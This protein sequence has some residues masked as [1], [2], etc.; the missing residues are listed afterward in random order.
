[1]GKKNVLLGIIL[2]MVLILSL[3]IS[4][5]RIDDVPTTMVKNKIKQASIVI[6][7]KDAITQLP[8]KDSEYV[9][10][11]E[12][13]GEVIETMKT[14]AAGKATSRL[15]DYEATSYII[16]QKQ[17]MLPYKLSDVE[18]L[19]EVNAPILEFEDTNQMLDYVKEVGRTADGQIEIKKVLMNVNTLMQKPELPNGCEIVS[20]TAV[21][22]YYGYKVTKTEMSD[23]YL[24]KESFAVNENKLY[25]PDPYKAYGGNPRNLNGAFFS[26]SPPIVEAAKLYFDAVGGR[27]SIADISGS[28]KEQIIEYLNKGIPVVVWITLDLSK[29]QI[30]AGWYLNDSGE[31]FPAPVNLHVVVL[32][33]YEENLVHVM[34]PLEGQVTYNADTFFKSYDEIGSHALIVGN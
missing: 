29:P 34:N 19:V 18:F 12:A 8:I 30:N 14:D 32:N 10:M 20:L 6:I 31:Y 27:N 33:G 3:L 9:I 21:L 17:V 22:N 7:N 2:G 23:T 15:L 28:S 4:K 25:G 24:P 5:E 16:K 13:S 11:R 1:M 26:Y